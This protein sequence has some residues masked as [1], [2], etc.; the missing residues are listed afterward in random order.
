MARNA[1]GALEALS[2]A[3]SPRIALAALAGPI[4]QWF[5][6]RFLE[7]SLGQRFAWPALTAGK[8]LF[9]CAPTGTGKTLAAFLPIVSRLIEEPLLGTLRCLY[10]AP[11]KALVHDTRRTLRRHFAALHHYL[12]PGAVMPTVACRTGD[13]TAYE[14]RRLMR[15]PPDILLTTPESLALMLTQQSAG[16]LLGSIRW[17]VVD[18]V[19]AFAGTKRGAD[20]SLSLERVEE[21]AGTEVQRIGL[22]ATCSPITAGACFLVGAQRPCAFAR[23]GDGTSLDLL[24]EPLPPPDPDG[25]LGQQSFIGRLLARLEAEFLRNRTTLIFTNVRSLAE[26]LTWALRRRYPH[27]SDQVAVHHSALAAS[28]RRKGERRLKRGRWRVVVSS[29]SLELGIDI[30]HVDSVVLVHP[31]GGVV[32]LLQRIGRSGHEPG[33]V[34][35]GLILTATP[36]ELLEATVTGVAGRTAQVDGLPCPPPPLDVLCQHLLGMAVQRLWDPGEAFAIIRRAYPFRDLGRKDFEDC[37]AYLSGRDAEGKPW[38]PARLSWEENR[39]TLAGEGTARLLRR[40]LGTIL[41]EETRQVR[42]ADGPPVGQ[43]DEV[44]AD[45]LQPGDRFVLDGR[46]FEFKGEQDRELAVEEVLGR[47]RV[48]HWVGDGWPL[49]TDLARRLYCLRTQAADALRDG[50]AALAALLRRD[51]Q[52]GPSAVEELVAY[53]VRQE[54]VSEIPGP[55]TCLIE[56]VPFDGGC[57]YHVHTPLGRAGNDALA[58]VAAWRLARAHGRTVATAVA[59]LGL[60]LSVRGELPLNAVTFR[61]LLALENLD[62]DLMIALAESDLLRERFRRMALTGLMILRNPRGGQRRVGGPDWAQRRLFDQVRLA[63]P[64][65]VLMRQAEREVREECCD[66]A[67]ARVYAEA[68]PRLNVRCRWLSDVSPFAASWT[69]ATVGAVELAETP[70]DALQRLHAELT[71]AGQGA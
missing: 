16:D 4:R 3:V 67:A 50:P 11:L 47:P 46:C 48:P 28:V 36:A 19:H 23:V 52:C 29:T 20:L 65:F 24:I 40:N 25:A 68:L 30:G 33:R 66:A 58:R 8:N 57:D 37:L 44:F 22:S 7:P 14:R 42:L 64:D 10:I 18:E 39:F 38:L 61:A 5:A 41:T 13:T 2:L 9:L 54:C 15:D 12:P 60:T 35:R 6:E 43:V 32:R 71:G 31:P 17:M 55:M 70:E 63:N 49:N 51:Y 59:D 27:W 53:F 62:A 1:P 69:Q 45:R 21:L 26:R 56:C 34:R